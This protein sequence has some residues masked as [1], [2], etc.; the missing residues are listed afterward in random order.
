MMALLVQQGASISDSRAAAISV[1]LHLLLVAALVPLWLF[2][3]A[4]GLISSSPLATI[5]QPA[6]PQEQ[7][8]LVPEIAAVFE[9]EPA[10]RPPE[11]HNFIRT[12]APQASATPPEKAPFESDHNTR[13]GS[14]S[15]AD[16]DGPAF[17][18]SQAGLDIPALEFL[19]QD[20]TDGAL[21]GTPGLQ[22]TPPPPRETPLPL[23]QPAP[24]APAQPPPAENLATSPD[25]APITIAAAT[26]LREPTPA[27]APAPKPADTPPEKPAPPAQNPGNAMQSETRPTRVKGGLTPNGAAPSVDA[28]DTP[29]GRYQRQVTSAI[30]KEWRTKRRMKPDAV[31]YGTIELEFFV[32]KSGTI[33]GLRIKNPRGAGPIM[34]DFTLSAV[35]E[36]R[37]PPIPRDVLDSLGKD[38]VPITYDII[39]Y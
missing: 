27:P 20:F 30:E 23:P 14:S 29:M 13:A 5:R 38:R 7:E 6:A 35:L 1:G 25:G 36:A 4:A 28:A 2:S 3:I 26:P 31:T 9:P 24:P 34:Q 19:R 37:V 15:P 18:P 8:I 11:Q 12:T 22:A 32:N 21:T 17:L 39:V 33:E 16:P 10:P